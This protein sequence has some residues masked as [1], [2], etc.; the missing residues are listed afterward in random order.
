MESKSEHVDLDFRGRSI[1]KHEK[2]GK[3]RKEKKREK[4][5]DKTDC[6]AYLEIRNKEK[7]V[8]CL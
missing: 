2:R 3:K 1:K 4:I 6:T 7:N 8:F 5:R